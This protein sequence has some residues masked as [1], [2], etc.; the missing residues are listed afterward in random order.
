MV[1]G[2][3]FIDWVDQACEDYI[4]AK[5][6]RVPFPQATKYR[7]QEELELVHSDLCDPISPPTPTRNAYFLLQV[8]NMSRFMWLTLLR[9][10]ASGDHVVPS[11]C[12]ARVRQEAESAAH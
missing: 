2:L 7:A 9:S 5:Q 3:P 4:L 8:D 12:R 10:K 11:S 6:K 1:H